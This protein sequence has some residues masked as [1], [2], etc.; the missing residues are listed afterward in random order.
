MKSDSQPF[1]SDNGRLVWRSGEQI[2]WVE[3]WGRDCL[4]VR[5]AVLPEMPPRD[6][7]LLPPARTAAKISVEPDQARIVNGKLTATVD[8]KS[9]RARFFKTG[10]DEPLVEEIFA[11]INYPPSRT[12]KSVG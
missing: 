3:P 9:G 7:S 1:S 5:V 4:R 8:A 10:S 2:F 6:W 12:F 11:R